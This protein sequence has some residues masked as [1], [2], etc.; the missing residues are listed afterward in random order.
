M[1]HHD[2]PQRIE[3]ISTII[4]HKKVSYLAQLDAP[5][6]QT[7]A[8]YATMLDNLS[9]PNLL[10]EKVTKELQAKPYQPLGTILVIV[11]EGYALA[12]LLSII[13]LLLTFNQGVVKVH[14]TKAV[15]EDFLAQ[16]GDLTDGIVIDEWHGSETWQHFDI[17]QFDAAL[18]AGGEPLL[19]QFRQQTPITMRLIEF[20]PK[21]SVVVLGSKVLDYT[22][23]TTQLIDEYILFE[24]GVCSSPRFIF[25][26]SKEDA[27]RLY[28][29][30]IDQCHRFTKLNQTKR[31][32]QF[33]KAQLLKV[34]S[35]SFSGLVQWTFDA[36]TGWIIEHFNDH[37]PPIASVGNVTLVSG[38]IK[39]HLKTIE[40]QYRGRLQV[41]GYAPNLDSML[42]PYITKFTRIC[43]LGKMHQRGFSASHD[44]MFELATLV[45]FMDWE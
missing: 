24:Q 35:K 15:V 21:I 28:H 30:L 3:I 23:I 14:H 34:N 42:Y 2:T 5:N 10:E 44:G 27:K 31:L 39:Y 19:Q 4:K 12:P 26:E 45:N 17:H 16:L 37:L 29:I 33:S 22:E 25:I 41:L 38:S 11:S 8:F 43:P 1:P 18:L 7:K 40:Q 6:K 9:D 32:E 20:G 13:G 36:T